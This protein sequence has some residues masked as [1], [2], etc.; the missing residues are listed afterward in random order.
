MKK[1]YTLL[2]SGYRG[3]NNY[4]VFCESINSVILEIGI[5]GIILQGECKTGTD[6]LAKNGP[7]KIISNVYHSLPIGI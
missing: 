2:I 3:F 5:P 6:Q 7:K 4:E 1:N